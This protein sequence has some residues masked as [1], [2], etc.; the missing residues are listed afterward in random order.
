MYPEFH[1]EEPFLI[2]R[3]NHLLIHLQL[4][5]RILVERKLNIYVCINEHDPR[6]DS[7]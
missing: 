3:F 5:H 1:L 6:I 7:N 2:L 4:L